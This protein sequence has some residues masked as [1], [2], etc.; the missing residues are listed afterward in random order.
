MVE[1]YCS[2]F[3]QQY[4]VFYHEKFQKEVDLENQILKNKNIEIDLEKLRTELTKRQEF[5]EH[6][7]KSKNEEVDRN[8]NQIEELEKQVAELREM[9]KID[10][11]QE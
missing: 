8:L 1:C 2:L 10:D 5:C 11:K 6:Y 7:I 3:L 4:E 9:K